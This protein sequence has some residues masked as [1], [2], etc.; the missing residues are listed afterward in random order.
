MVAALAFRRRRERLLRLA[1]AARHA[2]ELPTQS[3]RQILRQIEDAALTQIGHGRRIT[4]SYR[5]K[6]RTIVFSY[7]FETGFEQRRQLHPW[8]VVVQEV[9]HG[10]SRATITRQEWVTATVQGPACH[11]VPFSSTPSSDS[12]EAGN[13][14][15][16]ED[17]ELWR[18]I[19]AGP[20]GRWLADQPRDRTWEILPGL[21]VGYQ[22]GEIQADKLE[23]LT[24]TAG[25]LAKQLQH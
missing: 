24:L 20:V 18:S 6:G 5:T 11:A 4:A 9:D 19:L 16:V 7:E 21:V 25:E 10:C 23:A 22:P 15:I 2:W 3:N 1:L 14:A 12:Q 8:L 17:P 13:I